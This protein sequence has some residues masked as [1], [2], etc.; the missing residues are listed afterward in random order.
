MRFGC[1]L[2]I[3]TNQGT[4]FINDVIRYFIDHFNLRHTSFIVYYQEGNGQTKSTN[5]VFGSLLTKLVN[6]NINDWDEHVHNLI[7]ILNCLQS[8]H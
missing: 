2:T 6:E 8:W 3:V 4:H 5:M 7:F 1:P